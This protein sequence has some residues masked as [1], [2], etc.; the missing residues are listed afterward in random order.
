MNW[1]DWENYLKPVHLAGATHTVKIERIE[2]EEVYNGKKREPVPVC[3]F[4]GAKRGLVLSASRRKALAA[5]FGDD[6][7][8]AIGKAVVL[9]LGKNDRGGETIVIKPAGNGNGHE[10]KP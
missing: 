6:A 7:A 4:A 3:Y 9:A 10:V 2:I 8:A 5:M 1:S